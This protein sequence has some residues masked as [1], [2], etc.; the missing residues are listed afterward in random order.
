MASRYI[1]NTFP[2]LLTL[3]DI[4]NYL[5]S[6]VEDI[7]KNYAPLSQ[8]SASSL[9]GLWSG[10]TGIA[11]LFLR[12]SVAQPHLT[13]QGHHARTWAKSYIKGSRGTLHLS[14][15]GCG[16]GDEKLCFDAVAAC[17][18]KDMSHVE[19]LVSSIPTIIN[20]DYPDELLYGRAGTLYLLRM[21][22]H[23]VPDSAELID[24]AVAQ[25]S[26]KIVTDGPDWKWHG[27]RYLGAVHG[28]VG[29][30]TQLVLGTPALASRFESSL[31]GL[32]DGQL[33][34]GN[35]PSSEGHATASLVQF[36]HGAP[37]FVHA[38]LSLREHFPNLGERIDEAVRKGRECIWV[39]GLL[40]KEPCLCHGISGNALALPSGGQ[41]EHFLAVATPE[42]MSELRRHDQTLFEAADHGKP[43]SLTTSYAP[44]AAW[45]YVVCREEPARMIAFNDV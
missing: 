20:G 2:E 4:D 45:A 38:L 34:D 31:A 36:C 35:W 12:I 16:I 41:R 23:W 28:D 3:G 22:R 32:L 26:Q 29:I 27:K 19:S 11:Y 24:D 5:K 40:R 37:G 30:V 8:Y 9:E 42:R 13:V 43:Y 17:I 21:V 6:S 39:K 7:L 14:S 1:P 18:T 10:P 15:R 25:V 44:C 33:G